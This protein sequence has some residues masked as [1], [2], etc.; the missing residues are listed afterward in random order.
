MKKCDITFK[1]A[2]LRFTKKKKKLK[3]RNRQKD[4]H[5]LPAC[6]SFKKVDLNGFKKNLFQIWRKRYDL[7]PSPSSMKCFPLFDRFCKAHDRTLTL[8]TCRLLVDRYKNW[9]FANLWY[10]LSSHPAKI[11]WNI[12]KIVIVIVYYESTYQLAVLLRFQ[13]ISPGLYSW[14]SVASLFCDFNYIIIYYEL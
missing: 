11:M 7:F 14:T 3:K 12:L 6:L 13:S 9:T 4:I 10:P 1:K 5:H 8:Y 2:E